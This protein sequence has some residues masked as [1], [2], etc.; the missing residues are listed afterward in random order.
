MIPRRLRLPRA[1]FASATSGI[2]SVSPHF[3]LTVRKTSVSG[4]CAAVIS[5]KVAKRAVDRH[6]LKRR[7]FSVMR[8]WC[9][10]ARSI[11]VY[12]RAGSGALP[13]S[14]LKRELAEL[15]TRAVGEAGA[16]R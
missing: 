14:A 10:P 7:I 3:S 13:F 6:L 2:R 11:I 9:D 8:P 1:H 4:G 16:S 12:A 15:L 5:K